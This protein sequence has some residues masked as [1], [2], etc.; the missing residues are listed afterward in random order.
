MHPV[1]IGPIKLYD[2][3]SLFIQSRETLSDPVEAEKQIRSRLLKMMAPLLKLGSEV[4]EAGESAKSYLNATEFLSTD[5]PG[6]E[7]EYPWWKP[8]P[9]SPFMF[10]PFYSLVPTD[11]PLVPGNV[12]QHR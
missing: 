3:P 6:E 5:G 11:H 12:V 8:V 4:D 9:V 2:I 7:E 10:S 1:A